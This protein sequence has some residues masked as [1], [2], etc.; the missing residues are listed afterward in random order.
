MGTPLAGWQDAYYMIAT[1]AI[2]DSPSFTLETNPGTYGAG[3][4]LVYLKNHPAFDINKGIIAARKATG[5]SVLMKDA[6][7]RIERTPGTV[8]PT[9]SFEMDFD[10]DSCFIPLYTLFQEREAAV[11]TGTTQTF[12]TYTG[13][14]ANNYASLMRWTESGY[15]HKIVGAIPNSVTIS[16]NEGEAITMTVEWSGADMSTANTDTPAAWATGD[17]KQFLLFQ[18]MTFQFEDS[19][20]V[21]QSGDTVGFD[22]TITNNVVSKHYDHP[23]MQRHIL[24]DLSV[25]GTLRVPWSSTYGGQNEFITRLLDGDDFKVYLFWG[26]QVPANDNDV[27]ITLNIEPDTATTSGGEE[28]AINEVAF[29]GIYDATN[30]PIKIEIRS[31]VDRS[32][33]YH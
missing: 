3:K 13:S 26:N 17:S 29:T 20:G 9:T 6:S 16:G 24:G 4:P 32:T 22:I 28:E 5:R 7:V 18:D 25:T 15:S 2:T 31:A 33:G 19:S 30:A 14:T 21:I 23:S 1:T 10:P 8:A 27:S 12:T 11:G